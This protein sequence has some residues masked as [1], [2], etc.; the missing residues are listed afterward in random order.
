MKKNS[1]IMGTVEKACIKVA[2]SVAHIDWPY[3]TLILHEPRLPKKL[4]RLNK[5]TIIEE[6]RLDRES[7]NL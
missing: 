6:Q 3:C 4:K 7:S 2:Y 5:Q 1:L